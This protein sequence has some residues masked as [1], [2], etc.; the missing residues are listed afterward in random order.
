MLEA[1]DVNVVYPGAGPGHEVHALENVSLTIDEGDFVVA[2]GASGCGKTTFL[3]VMAGFIQPTS[4]D[5]LLGDRPILGPGRDRGVVFQK[6]ALLPWLD[7]LDNV[8]FGLKLQGMGKSERDEIARRNLSLV[9]LE[10]FERHKIYQLSGGMQQR[11]GLARALDQRPRDAAH[12][13][14]PGRPR[15]TDPRDHAGAD[16]R[17]L[18]RDRQDGLLHH[19]RRRGSALPGDPPDW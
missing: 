6:H 3:N 14:A 8:E 5:I 11:V 16:P 2:L 17:R 4:G 19:P 10:G 9:G 18:A 1:R 12:G 7:I 15:R 13:R